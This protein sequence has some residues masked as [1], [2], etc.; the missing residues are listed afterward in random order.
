[1][2]TSSSN[3]AMQRMRRGAILND[4]LAA[5]VVRD[6]MTASEAERVARR[7]EAA[8]P[9]SGRNGGRAAK[10]PSAARA[11]FLFSVV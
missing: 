6:A 9:G 10:A 2:D 3:N 5:S 8:R 7:V 11:A 1:M 4:S